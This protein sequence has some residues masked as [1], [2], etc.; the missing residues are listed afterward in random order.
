[1]QTIRNKSTPLIL[2]TKHNHLLVVKYCLDHGANPN[3]RDRGNLRFPR[4]QSCL[5]L[6]TR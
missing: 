5:G 1:M 3:L 6:R 2:G 4:W